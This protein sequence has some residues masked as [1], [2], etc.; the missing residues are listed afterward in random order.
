MRILYFVC[1]IQNKYD[2]TRRRLSTITVFAIRMTPIT[3]RLLREDVYGE[4]FE[5]IVH[6]GLTPGMRVRDSAIAADLGVS[7]TPVRE[8]LVR[9]AEDGFLDADAGRGFRVRALALDEVL[10]TYPIL[11]TLEGLGLRSSAPLTAD[12]LARLDEINATLAGAITVLAETGVDAACQTAAFSIALP[13]IDEL[14]QGR[15][16]RQRRRER[17]VCTID[18]SVGGIA[19]QPV[20]KTADGEMA[21]GGEGLFIVGVDDQSGDFVVL[22]RNQHF[23]QEM[24]E[25]QVSQSHLRGHALAIGAD[26]T[27]SRQVEAAIRAVVTTLGGLD[28]ALNNAGICIH[29]E[30]EREIRAVARLGE[31]PHPR[32][33]DHAERALGADEQLGQV[34]A[35]V[36]LAEPAQPVPDAA[37]GQHDLEAEH[38]LAGHAV[39]Q[40]RGAAGVGGEVA[41]DLDHRPVRAPDLRPGPVVGVLGEGVPGG[42]SLVDASVPSLRHTT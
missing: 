21:D 19:E 22:V 31:H 27:D 28:I 26:V 8:A 23:L 20:A 6:G 30:S 37:V 17:N 10:D 42:C 34:V 33:G 29:A 15:D 13:A 16:S 38:Q 25:G 3:R 11:W 24:A 12:Q 35:G 41:A 36:V 5:R 1:K 32:L 7:R 4:V 39:A 40:H 14:Q 2:A 9:L 18:R